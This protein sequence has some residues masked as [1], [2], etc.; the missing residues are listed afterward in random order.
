M[1]TDSY[2]NIQQYFSFS[3]YMKNVC[4]I[5]EAIRSGL[6]DYAKL[7]PQEL[8]LKVIHVSKEYDNI[9][10][11]VNL[12]RHRELIDFHY[13]LEG[14]D[15]IGILHHAKCK[16]LMMDYD[17]SSDYMLYSDE[18]EDIRELKPGHFMIITPEYAHSTMNGDG[19]VNKIIV[20]IPISR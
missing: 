7:E 13:V 10:T 11:R 5:I 2:T 4:S 16:H 17:K 8:E 9:R 6:I 19:Y 20:K 12:E 14:K 15:K 18:P 3:P 1:I